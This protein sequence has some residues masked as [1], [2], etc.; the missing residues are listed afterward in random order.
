MKLFSLE[1]ANALIPVLEP[2]LRELWSKRTALA[3]ELLEHDPALRPAGGRGTRL[4]PGQRGAPR[5]ASELKAEIVRIVHRIE[6]YGCV[7]KDLNLGLLDFP[8]L[9]DGRPVFLCWKAGEES[10]DHWHAFDEGFAE[11]KEL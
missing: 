4:R 3:I 6:A 5:R 11:R 10:I 2:L 1:K 9:R 8:A 7:I